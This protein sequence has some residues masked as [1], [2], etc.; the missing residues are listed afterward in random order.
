M[1]F[2]FCLL[3]VLIFCSPLF[4]GTGLFAQ[5]TTKSLAFKKNS[6]PAKHP[7]FYR[8]DLSYKLHQ[9]FS[10]IRLANSGDP[11]A[12]HELG[13][14][15][16][17]GLDSETDTVQAAFWIGKA[18]EKDLAAAC[19]NYGILLLNG[20]GVEWDPFKAFINFKKAAEDGM[21]AAQYI[22]GILYTDNLVVKKDLE[23]AIAWLN[24][25]HKSGYEPAAELLEEL[26]KKIPADNPD[27]SV[28]APKQKSNPQ[29]ASVLVYIDFDAEQDTSLNV[30]PEDLAD[31]LFLS[32]NKSLIS[33]GMVYTENDSSINIDSVDKDLLIKAANAGSPEALT[34]LGYIYSEGRGFTADPVK[35]AMLYYTAAKFESRN[36]I[37]LLWQLGRSDEFMSLLESEVKSGNSEAIYLL[38]GLSSFNF[39]NVLSEQQQKDFLFRAVKLNNRFA[40]IESGLNIY[41]GKYPEYKKENG[42]EILRQGMLSGDPVAEQ[43]YISIFIIDSSKVSSDQFKALG[44][45][46][47]DGS[48]LAESLLGY[49]YANGVGVNAS[50]PAAV[51]YLRSSAH[52]GSRFAMQQL[53]KIY[54]SIRPDD[55]TFSLQ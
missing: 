40:V 23:Q 5:D 48:I 8:P 31:A 9:Q 32:G 52:R 45:F 25:S 3:V 12:Q 26:E 36:A 7:L 39:T 35:G 17:Q 6:H 4:T 49:C 14:R 19:Y 24:K 33:S 10:L 37:Y 16:L 55:E 15:F 1:K 13:L 34:L 46:A 27:S 44:T 54:D 38:Y 2:Y 47:A 42:L 22:T 11:L 51:K 21:P 53:E 50:K 20:W 43:R 41:S 28:S 30:T 29:S 18:A